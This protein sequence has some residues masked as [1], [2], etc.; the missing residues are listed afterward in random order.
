[1]SE[2]ASVTGCNSI[3]GGGV[4]ARGNATESDPPVFTMEGSSS[5]TDCT[6]L[7]GGGIFVSMRGGKVSLSGS[8]KI[9]NCRAVEK[10]KLEF[11]EVTGGGVHVS[12]GSFEMSGGSIESCT[13]VN[14][15][16][17]VSQHGT[18]TAKFTV[19]AKPAETATQQPTVTP[20][21]Q[22]TVQPVSPIPSTGDTANPALWFALLI[23]SGSALAAIFVLRRKGNRK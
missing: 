11:P 23:V 8:A 10:V 22:P 20:Q 14:T 9:E 1:M 6:A 3:A 5:I 2:N 7:N 15:L 19:K 13:A 17:I 12:S 16:A 18:A 21:P 4:S